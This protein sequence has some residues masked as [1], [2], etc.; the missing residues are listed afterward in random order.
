M[1]RIVVLVRMREDEDGSDS[2][3]TGGFA[4]G[5]KKRV[6]VEEAIL[7]WRILSEG[8]ACGADLEWDIFTWVCS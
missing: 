1:K 4:R 2:G 5:F 3:L 8:R 6:L 7:R